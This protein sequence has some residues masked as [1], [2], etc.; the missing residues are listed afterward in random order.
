MY[1]GQLYEWLGLAIFLHNMERGPFFI[2]EIKP[3]SCDVW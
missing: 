3:L 1:G 2:V